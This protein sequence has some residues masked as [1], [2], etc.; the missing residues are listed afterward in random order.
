M[1]ILQDEEYVE[2]LIEI[3][4]ATWWIM[5]IVRL[6]PADL[7]SQPDDCSFYKALY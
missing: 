3:Y 2:T 7:M 6:G 4:K 1:D 5:E